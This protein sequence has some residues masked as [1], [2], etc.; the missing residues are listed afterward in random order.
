MLIDTYCCFISFKLL[1]FVFNAFKST[2][3]QRR[4]GRKKLHFLDV[5]N[6]SGYVFFFALLLCKMK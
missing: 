3:W 5:N 1:N 4:K 2:C 6:Q